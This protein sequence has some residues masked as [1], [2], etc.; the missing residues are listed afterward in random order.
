VATIIHN[1]GPVK[2]HL[3]IF[4][5]DY[6]GLSSNL[7]HFRAGGVTASKETPMEREYTEERIQRQILKRIGEAIRNELAIDPIPDDLFRLVTE[8]D[9][10]NGHC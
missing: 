8:L 6:S 10:R 4:V 1:K 5:T 2:F 9:R 3:A 7:N